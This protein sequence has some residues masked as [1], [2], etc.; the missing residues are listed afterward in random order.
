MFHCPCWLP[1]PSWFT[2]S[3]RSTVWLTQGPGHR[4]SALN[5]HLARREMH[6]YSPKHRVLFFSKV[7]QRCI[8]RRELLFSARLLVTLGHSQGAQVSS[9]NS[10][11]K[12]LQ[13]L[14]KRVSGGGV[15]E[16]GWKPEGGDNSLRKQLSLTGR[17]QGQPQLFVLFP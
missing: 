14:G 9:P 17:P 12:S 15:K 8:W 11:S 3:A 16:R 6:V 13:G 2:L 10:L 7:V 5:E 1:S 4:P